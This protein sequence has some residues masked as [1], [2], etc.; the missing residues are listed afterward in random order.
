MKV[1]LECDVESRIKVATVA[2]SFSSG[3]D[4]IFTSNDRGHITK[5]KVISKVDKPELFFSKSIP[6]AEDPTRKEIIFSA[7]PELIKALI[8]EFQYLEGIL[9]FKGTLQKI[10]WESPMV[11]YLPE[12]EKEKEQIEIP[13]YQVKRHRP[14]AESEISDQDLCQLIFGKSRY[15]LLNIPFSFF[16]E[17]LNEFNSFRFINAFF[18]SYFVLEGLYG[19]GKTKNHAIKS[20]FKKSKEATENIQWIVD[21]YPQRSEPQ[22]IR[23]Y[24]TLLEMLKRRN[25]AFDV[26]GIIE[27]LVRT[28][29][30]LHHFQF[31]SNR[32]QAS[33]LNQEEYEAIA[34]LSL[35]LAAGAI[36]QA[37]DEIDSYVLSIYPELGDPD[38]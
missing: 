12:T 26:D 32:Q 18:N 24:R 19:N 4:Y 15:Y 10:H 17:G 34:T 27:L 2:F 33:P 28:R 22:E 16:R 38:R 23:N 36:R 3:R 8:A 13:F 20:E 30:D 5:I 14:E 25:K 11:E 31:H 1:S 21:T 35:E 6:Q 7:D 37:M 29:G 9:S